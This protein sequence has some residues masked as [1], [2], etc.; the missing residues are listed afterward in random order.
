MESASPSPARWFRALRRTVSDSRKSSNSSLSEEVIRKSRSAFLFGKTKTLEFRVAQLEAI[1]QM[2]VDHESQFVEALHKDLHRP[3][4]ETLL[5]EITTVKNEARYAINNLKK[6][7]QPAY[8]EKSMTSLLDVGFVQSEPVGVVLIIGSWNFP[9]QQVL[10]PMVGAI[11]AGNCVILKP[12][13]VSSSAAELL[14]T[15]LSKC[16]D[17]ECYHVICGGQADLMELLENRFDHIFFTGDRSTGKMVAQAAAKHLTPVSLM[18]GGKNPCYVDKDCDIPLS[19]KKIAWARFVNAGQ[20][21]LAPEYVLCHADVEDKLVE[22]LRLCVEEFY[23]KNPQESPHFGRIVSVEHYKHVTELLSCGN[24]AF[25]GQTEES[26]KYIAPTVL[27]GVQESDAVMQ[28]DILGPVLPVL[29]VANLD[30]AIDFINKKDRPLATYVYSNSSQV[31]SEMMSRTSSGSFCS[32][33][34]LIQSLCISLPRGGMVNSGVGAY[35]GKYTFDTFSHSR[36][37]LLRNR[38]IECVTYLRYPPYMDK[39]LNLML[40]ASSLLHKKDGW[41]QII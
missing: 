37:F 19:A 41:C 15:L 39:N 3:R 17:N 4:F 13:E 21:S 8:I 28:Q 22:N 2:L 20:T 7:M 18:L 34:S 6:W 40:W 29:S 35:G 23:G 36:S 5:S 12:S 16:L 1:F 33:D 9:I 27:L 26:D 10:V 38:A 11:A 25:G 24:V 32:N 31:V 14:N 30:E